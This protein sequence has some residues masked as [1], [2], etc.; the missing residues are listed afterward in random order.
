MGLLG[1]GY[2]VWCG[3]VQR[4]FPRKP[5]L[6]LVVKDGEYVL[7][8]AVLSDGEGLLQDGGVVPISVWED[9]MGL[10]LDEVAPKVG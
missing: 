9:G 1:L 3:G 6:G 10:A 2:Y 8:E 5:I 4:V 7:R